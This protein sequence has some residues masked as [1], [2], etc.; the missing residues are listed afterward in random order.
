[1]YAGIYACPSVRPSVRLSVCL[2]ECMPKSIFHFL[3]FAHE[4]ASQNFK[5][6]IH[7]LVIT[8]AVREILSFTSFMNSSFSV[9]LPKLNPR[10]IRHKHEEK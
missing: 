3:V 9:T 10:I 4:S 1:M 2:F 7:L 8:H 6:F 5:Y